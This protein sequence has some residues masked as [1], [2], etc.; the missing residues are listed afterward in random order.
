[1]R[2]DVESNASL[3]FVKATVSKTYSDGSTVRKKKEGRFG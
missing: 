1:M 2:P 3:H